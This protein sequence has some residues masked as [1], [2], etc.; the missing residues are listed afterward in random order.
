[1][2]KSASRTPPELRFPNR[3]ELVK[4][5]GVEIAKT[6]GQFGTN[7]GGGRPLIA[8]FGDFQITYFTPFNQPTAWLRIN[9]D[10]ST[11]RLHLCGLTIASKRGSCLHVLWNDQARLVEWFRDPSKEEWDR[12]LR[13][14][15]LDEK[16]QRARFA[17]RYAR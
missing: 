5:T 7:V 1:M 17:L 13:K 2:I 10:D 9:W 12:R 6:I 15:W 8:W 3:L 16:K 14:Q 4:R 11:V